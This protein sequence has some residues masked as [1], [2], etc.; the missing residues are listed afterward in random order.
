MPS[1]P[2]FFFYLRKFYL[3][4]QLVVKILDRFVLD[5]I[6]SKNGDLENLDRKFR[7]FTKLSQNFHRTPLTNH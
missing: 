2:L 4:K 1:F 6:L 7:T 5:S 3:R